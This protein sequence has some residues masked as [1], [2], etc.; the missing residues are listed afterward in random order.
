[1]HYVMNRKFG[2]TIRT[3]TLTFVVLRTILSSSGTNVVF[4]TSTI[5]VEEL[6]PVVEFPT[7]PSARENTAGHLTE[8]NR[9]VITNVTMDIPFRL[10]NIMNTSMVETAT[11]ML[12]TPVGL[13]PV[14]NG[15][16]MKCLTANSRESM[17]STTV[18][19]LVATFV[20]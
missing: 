1:M 18:V 13:N 10:R 17:E 20:F 14:T 11:H 5:K 6:A 15:A 2:I 7:F 12:R 19:A 8:T 4:I 9:H 3:V 16:A